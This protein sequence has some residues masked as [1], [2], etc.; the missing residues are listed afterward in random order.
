MIA[1]VL[2]MACGKSYEEEKKERHA[3]QQK[4]AKEND[5]ALKI[6]VLPTLDCLPLYVAKELNLF[7]TAVVDVRLKP[8]TAQMDCDTALVGRTVEGAVTD[9]VRAERLVSKGAKLHYVAQTGA[10]WLLFTNRN[11]RINQL[12]HLEDKM[13]AMTRYSV[14][15]LLTDRAVDSAK[16]KSEYVFRIQINDVFVRLQMLQNNMMDALWLTEPQATVARLAKNPI[17]LDSRRMGANYGVVA[18]NSQKM[19]T[20][21]RK[22]QLDAFVKGY[23]AACDSINKHGISYYRD[24]VARYCNVKTAVVDSLPKGIT[25]THA[26]GPLQQDIEKVN[27]WLKTSK[28]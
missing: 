1:A 26:R 27:N 25:F 4:L 24:L 16:V 12:K 19:K 22:Q 8:F 15:D 5:E 6:A 20:F 14:T 2:L 21:E 18:F 13:V 11:A 3:T 23:D 7:D 9:L 17:L 10:Y 28:K